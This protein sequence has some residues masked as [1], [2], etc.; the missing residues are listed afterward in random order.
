MIKGKQIYTNGIIIE[1]EWENINFIEAKINYPDGSIIEGI[2]K[3][4]ILIKGKKIYSSGNIFEGE[5]DENNIMKKVIRLTESD[6]TNV[7]ISLTIIKLYL[8]LYRCW[9]A[10]IIL[11]NLKPFL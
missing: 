4:N 6:L 9:I 2:W 1:G 11:L 10:I 5:W 3:N 8:K 7:S